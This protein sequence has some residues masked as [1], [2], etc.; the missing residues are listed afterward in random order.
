MPKTERDKTI[1]LA[2]WRQV[3]RYTQRQE[4]LV[5]PMRREDGRDYPV[6]ISYSFGHEP[7][8]GLADLRL[9]ASVSDYERSDGTIEAY[10]DAPSYREVYAVTA[11]RA[12]VMADLLA[13][14]EREQRKVDAYEH[15]DAFAVFAKVCGA[16]WVCCPKGCGDDLG[17]SHMTEGS[18]WSATRWVW[19]TVSEGRNQYRT[20]IREAIEAEQLRR[21]VK[22]AA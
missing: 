22:L 19:W 13:K 1:G 15:G 18:S 6:G 16:S 21:G 17:K 7:T 2:M 8:A 5:Q 3:N 14:F 10:R 4:V 12:K 11:G 9:E 20:L